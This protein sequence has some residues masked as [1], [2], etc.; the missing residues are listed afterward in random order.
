MLGDLRHL[1]T[2]TNRSWQTPESQYP[3]PVLTAPPTTVVAGLRS[4]N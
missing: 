1:V 3:E 4:G 2:H